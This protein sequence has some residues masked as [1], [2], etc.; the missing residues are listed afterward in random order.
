MQDLTPKFPHRSVTNAS[1]QDLTRK[2]LKGQRSACVSGGRSG[3]RRGYVPVV[4]DL[5][6]SQKNECLEMIQAAGLEPAD[7]RWQFRSAELGGLYPQVAHSPTTFYFTFQRDLSADVFHVEFSPGYESLAQQDGPGT[8]SQVVRV[9]FPNWLDYLKREYYAPDLWA[10]VEHQRGMLSA[11]GEGVENTPFTAKEQETIAVQLNEAKVYVRANFELDE[12]QFTR[13][14]SQLDY[15]IDAAKRVGRVD[16]RNLLIGSFLSLV[17]Q[18]V[19][20]TEPVRELLFVILRGSPRCSAER[21]P[22]C[23]IPHLNSPSRYVGAGDVPDW[24]LAVS[25]LAL[26]RWRRA[27][28]LP[29]CATAEDPR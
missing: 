17:V 9:Q 11:D 19:V 3:R 6:Q 4:L 14:E 12:G 13:F 16:W 21:C 23:R 18:S 10:E 8:W 22:S 27:P 25:D 2:L 15:L 24:E 5:L 26:T 1:V 29:T 7:F 20:P 28:G